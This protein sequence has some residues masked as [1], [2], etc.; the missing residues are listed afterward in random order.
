MTKLIYFFLNTILLK[1]KR[2]ELLEYWKRFQKDGI[3]TLDKLNY[4]IR[5]IDKSY[6][7]TNITVD[8]GSSVDEKIDS[9]EVERSKFKFH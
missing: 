3:N 4:K 8:I 6:L 2:F 9:N 1:T 5:S 7:F